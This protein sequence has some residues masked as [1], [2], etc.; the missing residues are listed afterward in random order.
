MGVLGITRKVD[1]VMSVRLVFT[2]YLSNNIILCNNRVI[3]K[4][5]GAVK[6]LGLNN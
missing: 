5:H 2:N 1:I 3:E 4:D 6:C